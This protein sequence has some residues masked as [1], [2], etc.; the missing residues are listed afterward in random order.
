MRKSDV[1]LINCHNE[2][3]FNSK[4]DVFDILNELH[5]NS[6]YEVGGMSV[7]QDETP[8]YSYIRL[9]IYQ[10]IRITLNLTKDDHYMGYPLI[11]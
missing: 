9:L 7:F 8:L 2:D 4:T 10:S 1:F 3:I 6:Q 5:P 11:N